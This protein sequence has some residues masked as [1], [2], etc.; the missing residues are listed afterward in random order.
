VTHCEYEGYC[1]HYIIDR[2]FG[3]FQVT[4]HP[5]HRD[6][7]FHAT[8]LEK[9]GIKQINVGDR[10]RFNVQPDERSGRHKA[11]DIQFADVRA[12]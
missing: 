11:T 10:V 3:F 12:A 2:G 4:S 6:I 9:A 5:N 7:F 8:E 1:K